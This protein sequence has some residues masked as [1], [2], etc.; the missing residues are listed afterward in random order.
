MLKKV[1]INE[2]EKEKTK[3]LQRRISSNEYKRRL[4]ILH[5]VCGDDDDDVFGDT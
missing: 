3:S 2:E 4:H 5:V 1:Q